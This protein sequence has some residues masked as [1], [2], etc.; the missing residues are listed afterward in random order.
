M[1]IWVLQYGLKKRIKMYHNNV[2]KIITEILNDSN[3]NIVLY[4][5][6]SAHQTVGRC[7][8]D[9]VLY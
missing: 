3:H 8:D 6:P 5:V 9:V 7:E 4:M 1:L 2:I